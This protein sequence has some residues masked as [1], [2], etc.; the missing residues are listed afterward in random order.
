MQDFN[1][2]AQKWNT[3]ER[4]AR[5]T[6][7]AA[8]IRKT[9]AEAYP[10]T[11][12]DYGAGTGL[13]ALELSHEAEL[14]VGYDP[15][16]GMREAF[17]QNVNATQNALV[18]KKL[19]P[20]DSLENASAQLKTHQPQAKGFDAVVCSLVLHHIEDVVATLKEMRTQQTAGGRIAIIDFESGKYFGHPGDPAHLAH[21]GFSPSEI[22]AHLGAAG[23]KEIQVETAYQGTRESDTGTEKPYRLF[24]ATATL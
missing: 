12:L 24:I 5:A 19:H 14:I 2:L 13:I 1:E 4:K 11:I 15:A 10:R 21:P 6:A 7:L 18:Q 17:Q 8:A 3:P 22:A 16:A 9:W 23:Y 20:A